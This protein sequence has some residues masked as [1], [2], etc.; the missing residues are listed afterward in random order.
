MLNIHEDTAFRVCVCMCVCDD[1][2]SLVE[3]ICFVDEVTLEGEE[4]VSIWWVGFTH[5]KP[6]YV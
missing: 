6:L 2:I 3:N 4:T 1:G 5:V